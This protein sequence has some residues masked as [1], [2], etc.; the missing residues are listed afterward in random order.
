MLNKIMILFSFLILIITVPAQASFGDLETSFATGGLLVE[1]FSASDDDQ[2][3]TLTTDSSGRILVAGFIVNSSQR[4]MLVARFDNG[5]LD[6][7]FGDLDGS[8]TGTRLG[9][10]IIDTYSG[11]NDHVN[12]ILVDGSAIYLVGTTYRSATKLDVYVAKLE[13]DGDLDTS[14]AGGAGYLNIDLG[15]SQNDQPFTAKLTTDHA[16]MIGGAY[17]GAS[18]LSA[19]AFVL[20]VL[21]DGT[22]D[23]NFGD[24]DGTGSARLGY[25]VFELSAD[26]SVAT[27]SSVSDLALDSTGSIYVVGGNMGTGR[28]S[29]RRAMLAKL[30]ALGELTVGSFGEDLGSG[31][32]G[33]VAFGLGNADYGLNV[34]VHETTAQTHIYVGGSSLHVDMSDSTAP[35]YSYDFFV[36]RFDSNGNLDAG[37]YG[38]AV[39]GTRPGYTH[40][41]TNGN[42]ES[43]NQIPVNL[44][45]LNDGS[46]VLIGRAVQ[47]STLADLVMAQFDENGDLNTSHFGNTNSDGS[48]TGY[49]TVDVSGSSQNDYVYDSTFEN[50]SLYLAGFFES[51]AGNEDV[52]VTAYSM[53]ATCGDGVI[54][55]TEVCDDGNT[56][57]GDGCSSTCDSE[58]DADGDGFF[59]GVDCNDNDSTINSS[60]TEVCG[61]G[62]DNDCDGF[63]QTCGTDSS[64][65]PGVTRVIGGGQLTGA[66]ACSLNPDIDLRYSLAIPFFFGLMVGVILLQRSRQNV[67][68]KVR[69]HNK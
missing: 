20:K 6:I 39:S 7:T 46:L 44:N 64:E 50:N 22:L 25:T 55:S 24:V 41:D 1:S 27:A 19:D 12:Q 18:S 31:Q 47:S 38:A 8:G 68:V 16:L 26:T 69:H 49:Y 42:S 9:Y 63:E 59:A 37:N 35:I 14:F 5:A 13:S 2:A 3:L 56:S 48:R 29:Q 51:S 34:L 58:V 21:S 36:G 53:N 33:M 32:T 52:Y 67:K 17:D 40:F 30:N 54:E 60:A 57:S 15:A 10:K 45:M 11:Q 66:G 43:P 23:S 4:D 62:I 61:D 65:S 28:S